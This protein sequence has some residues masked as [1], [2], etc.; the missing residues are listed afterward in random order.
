MTLKEIIVNPTVPPEAFEALKKIYDDVDQEIQASGVACWVRGLCCDFEKT[1]HVLYASSLEIA[2]VREI[3]PEPF[4]GGSCLC[5]FWKDGRCDERTRR[6]LGCRTYFCDEKYRDQLE[7]IYEKYYRQI[8]EVATQ[9]S[10]EWSYQPFVKV[11][12]GD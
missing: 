1:D 6:P 12:R 9:Y 11:M 4:E 7:A 10:L 8:T 3:H 2:Y 5:P